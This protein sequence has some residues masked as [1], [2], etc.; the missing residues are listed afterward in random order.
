MNK[1][2]VWS[3][4]FWAGQAMAFTPYALAFDCTLAKTVTEKAVCKSPALMAKDREL[5]A[6]YRAALASQPAQAGQLRQAQR[7]WIKA[8]DAACSG[9]EDCLQKRY[10]DRI[11]AL[12]QTAKAAPQVSGSGSIVFK[13]VT[14]KKT[15]PYELSLSYPKF[16]GAPAADVAF[17]NAYR[18]AESAGLQRVRDGRQRGGAAMSTRLSKSASSMRT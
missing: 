18:E 12:A 13:T 1:L 14:I 3:A 15:K 6:A 8:N 7:A 11:A 4:V 5:N 10:Q 17:L 2:F 16:E 9:S